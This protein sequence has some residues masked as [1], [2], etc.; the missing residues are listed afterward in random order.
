[1]T[2]R[3]GPTTQWSGLAIPF[4]E[5]TESAAAASEYRLWKRR[6]VPDFHGN[7]VSLE[8]VSTL[9][10]SRTLLRDDDRREPETYSILPFVSTIYRCS[11]STNCTLHA[12]L[13]Q[14]IALSSQQKSAVLNEII[15]SSR[16]QFSNSSIH[17]YCA[18]YH[19]YE[20]CRL[21]KR[22]KMDNKEY[23]F[24]INV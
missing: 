6:A 22:S 19:G 3:T 17:L 14:N 9:I 18:R 1:M 13:R 11:G 7:V 4:V 10:L 8:W 5:F 16:W 20:Q 2:G 21:S 15:C 12:T 23:Y 24:R